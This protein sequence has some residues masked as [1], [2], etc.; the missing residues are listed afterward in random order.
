MVIK[1]SIK[2]VKNLRQLHTFSAISTSL[3]LVELMEHVSTPIISAYIGVLL[4]PIKQAG[5]PNRAI[6]HV[7]DWQDGLIPLWLSYSTALWGLQMVLFKSIHNDWLLLWSA[8]KYIMKLEL[9]K[10]GSPLL[11][12]FLLHPTTKMACDSWLPCHAQPVVSAQWS[13]SAWYVCAVELPAMT[14]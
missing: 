11:C 1:D 3:L 7:R 12:V 13:C 10:D 8:Y 9:S 4:T 5:A 14:L 2:T 6:L